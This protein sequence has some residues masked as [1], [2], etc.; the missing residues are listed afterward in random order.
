MK[1]NILISGGTG[2]VGQAITKLLKDEDHEVAVLSRR[3]NVERIRSFYWNYENGELDRDAIEFADVI[4]HLAGENISSKKWSYEQKKKIIASRVQTTELLKSAIEKSKKKPKAFLSASAIGYYGSFTSE[5]IFSEEDEAGKDFLSETV[6][7]WEESIK[8]I[9]KTGIP[10]A[11]LRIA[12]VMSKNGG[13]LPRMLMPV[14]WGL[15]SAL[16]TGKQW[17]PWISLEDLARLFVFVLEERL[18]KNTPEN[19]EIYNATTPDHI[20]NSQM[21]KQLAEAI[22]RP[23][24]MPPVPSFVFKLM[25]GEM[26]MIL[27]NGSRVSSEK[28]QKQGFVFRDTEIKDLIR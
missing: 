7:K 24:F 3:K 25:F 11:V 15:G 21:M 4:F 2:M 28:I 16:G 26:S 17:I 12:V 8:Q 14:K 22:K 9:Q 6:V 5:R 10:T 18:L 27:L 23:Y 13:A 1:L 20:N 19:L